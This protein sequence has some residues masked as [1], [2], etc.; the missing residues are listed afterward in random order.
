MA[1][2]MKNPNTISFF[3]KAVAKKQTPIHIALFVSLLFLCGC[4][5]PWV[6]EQQAN[7]N[8]FLG[9]KQFT[10]QSVTFTNLHVGNIAETTY[11]QRKDQQQEQS[12]Q[13][14]KQALADLFAK[15]LKHRLAGAG[16]MLE[17]QSPFTIS[18]R[19]TR[20]EPGSYINPTE[21]NMSVCLL[22]GNGNTLDEVTICGVVPFDLFFAASSGQRI[23]TASG[24]LVYDFAH[25]LRQRTKK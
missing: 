10:L 6:A 8:P 15:Q 21:V 13:A 19:V 1:T 9:V 23:R 11:L 22:D 5:T 4:G 14:D 3:M 17:D 20:I 7:P 24:I 16:I 25:Y 18:P 2:L 12:W